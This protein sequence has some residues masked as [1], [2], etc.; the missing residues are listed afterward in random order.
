MG[1][2][3]QQKMLEQQ[4]TQYGERVMEKQNY[5]KVLFGKVS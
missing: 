5:V 4:K 2:L 3:T 1:I